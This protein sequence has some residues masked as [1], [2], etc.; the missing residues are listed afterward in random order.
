MGKISESDLQK[1]DII[2]STTSAAVSTVIRTG[3]ISRVSHARLYVGSGEVIEAVG[4]GVVRV[5][6]TT[7]MNED[8]LTVVYRRRNMSD[9]IA[10]IV[11]RFA[12]R[13]IGKA[14]DY[15][16]VAGAG[17]TTAGGTVAS[18]ISPLLGIGMSAGAISNMI[19]PD[20]KFFCSELVVRAFEEANAPI[21]SR[22]ATLSRPGDITTSHFLQY[23]GH[24][25]GE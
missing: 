6:L 21:I 17:G 10:D 3:S 22:P 13:Q 2:V 19:S 15:A 8:T 24:L 5:S 25:R 12:E 1:A 9:E 16:G 14:Y 7:A 20:S 18:I 4:S 11:I 23:V